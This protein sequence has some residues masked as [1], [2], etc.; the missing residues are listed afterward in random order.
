MKLIGK[1]LYADDGN[2]LCINNDGEWCGFWKSLTLPN[3]ES[4]KWYS[5]CTDEEKK[6][7]ER[8]HPQPEPEPEA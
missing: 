6:Q 8:E 1:D 2:W 3:E 4:A 5:E 7:W